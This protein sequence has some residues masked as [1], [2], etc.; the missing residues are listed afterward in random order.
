MPEF[1]PRV[2]AILASLSESP[3]PPRTHALLMRHYEQTGQFAKA[4]DALF[5]ILEAAPGD[6]A[7][8]D[9]GLAFYDRILR[10]SDAMLTAGNLPRAEAEQGLREL[11]TT[12]P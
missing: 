5:S 12:P 1:V 10:Q 6:A 9:F 8:I 4:E 3:L 7:V 11:K 2:E